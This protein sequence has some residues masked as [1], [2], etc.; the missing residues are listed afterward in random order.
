MC[1]STCELATLRAGNTCTFKVFFL[2]RFC[3]GARAQEPVPTT[4][5]AIER[6]DVLS[7][8]PD[9]ILEGEA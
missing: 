2:L 7:R 8:K 1:H 6:C 5:I 3:S 4:G 9:W